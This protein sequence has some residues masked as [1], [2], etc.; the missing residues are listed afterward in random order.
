MNI[1][2]EAQFQFVKSDY[3]SLREVIAKAI[4]EK[5]FCFIV[6]RI[7]LLINYFLMIKIW[8]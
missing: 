8:V 3:K 5:S 6:S 4:N 1:G 7:F 2:F